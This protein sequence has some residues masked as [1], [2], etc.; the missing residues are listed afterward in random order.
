M[1]IAKSVIILK[2]I[3]NVYIAR[4]VKFLTMVSASEPA[5]LDLQPLPML[6]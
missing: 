5:L 4:M 1:Q 2:A 3:V 6:L